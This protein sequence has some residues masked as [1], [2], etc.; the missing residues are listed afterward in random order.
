MTC[1]SLSS[2]QAALS[3]SEYT[4]KVDILSWKSKNARVH[5]QI[6]VQDCSLRGRK[7]ACRTDNACLSCG[8]VAMCV[9]LPKQSTPL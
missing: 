2:E 7:P 4:D 5:T 8:H 6:K 3:V 9:G 1:R